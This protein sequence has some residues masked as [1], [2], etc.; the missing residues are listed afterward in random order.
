M[1]GA[2]LRWKRAERRGSRAAMLQPVAIAA[3][4]GG[5]GRGKAA[6]VGVPGPPQRGATPR[7]DRTGNDRTGGRRARRLGLDQVAPPLMPAFAM[8]GFLE[9]AIHGDHEK[10]PPQR[11]RLTIDP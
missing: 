3:M 6:A 9:G 4:A 1:R 11:R 2:I 8:S 10:R 7:G 5:K